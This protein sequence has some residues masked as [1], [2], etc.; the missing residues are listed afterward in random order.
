MLK[1]AQY[2]ACVAKLFVA[3][4]PMP[5]FKGNPSASCRPKTHGSK[6]KGLMQ[7]CKLCRK[8]QNISKTPAEAAG[9]KIKGWKQLIEAATTKKLGG[10]IKE[11]QVFEVIAR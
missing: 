1:Q 8:H 10:K 11:E 7:T 9:I 2:K 3:A 5:K 4:K 6:Q